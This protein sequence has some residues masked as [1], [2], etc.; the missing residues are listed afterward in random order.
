VIILV[1]RFLPLSSSGLYVSDPLLQRVVLS[2]VNII[3][4]RNFPENSRRKRDIAL[5]VDIN[6]ATGDT[7]KRR[8]PTLERCV[9]WSIEWG[10]A[11][12]IYA[13]L[14]A[15]RHTDPKALREISDPVGPHNDAVLVLIGQ[16][17]DRTVVDS[18]LSSAGGTS[19]FHSSA[20]QQC[21]WDIHTARAHVANNPI[22]FARNMGAVALGAAN[23]DFFD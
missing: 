18:L 13:N 6:P 1:S 22:G 11:G 16:I 19:V 5:W 23:Q 2:A 21:F 7:E 15:A 17:A 3:L 10:A 9:R 4:L 8:C 14:F 12:L 20:I